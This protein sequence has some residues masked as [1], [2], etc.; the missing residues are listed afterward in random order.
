MSTDNQTLER[1][2]KKAN[3][4]ISRSKY[5]LNQQNK[6]D[7]QQQF[8]YQIN[9]RDKSPISPIT[10]Q[11]MAQIS[12]EQYKEMQI[13]R[14]QQQ[15][16]E[17][18]QN[19]KN[20]NQIKNF[21]YLNSSDE[22]D[23]FYYLQK[24]KRDTLNNSSEKSNKTAQ[25]QFQSGNTNKIQQNSNQN[26]KNYINNS[27]N[28]Q[29]NNN[30]NNLKFE[31]ILNSNASQQNFFLN[32]KIKNQQVPV[33]LY[34][35][36]F[37]IFQD[38]KSLNQKKNI[39]NQKDILQEQTQQNSKENQIQQEKKRQLS[40]FRDSFFSNADLNKENFDPN[41][42]LFNHDQ[43]I[44]LN[45]NQKSK[46]TSNQNIEKIIINNLDKQK[47]IPQNDKNAFNFPVKKD[48]QLKINDQKQIYQQ[49]L[50]EL[51]QNKKNQLKGL[52]KNLA[53]SDEEQESDDAKNDEIYEEDQN[54]L[55]NKTNLIVK[56][57]EQSNKNQFDN[58]KNQSPKNQ[59]TV[60]Y[61]NSL[62]PSQKIDL[63]I[64]KKLFAENLQE[65][66]D[67]Q[68]EKNLNN[69]EQEQIIEKSFQIK[70]T[71]FEEDLSANQKTYQKS[72]QPD[73]NQL[74]QQQI[75][76]SEK[77][78]L[79]TSSIKKNNEDSGFFEN[80]DKNFKVLIAKTNQKDPKKY[81]SNNTYHKQ[82]Q[83]IRKSLYG[84]F[85]KAWLQND[86]SAKKINVSNNQ[87]KYNDKYSNLTLSFLQQ[88]KEPKSNQNQNN[89]KNYNTQFSPLNFHVNKYNYTEKNA[90]QSHNQIN[91]NIPVSPLSN[92]QINNKNNR[93]KENK[94]ISD[95]ILNKKIG[96]TEKD[97]EKS[98]KLKFNRNQS[99]SL[100]NEKQN[101]KIINNPVKN[102][103]NQDLLINN[104]IQ[105]HENRFNS[106]N[107]NRNI[108]INFKNNNS[109]SFLTN[110]YN[111]N[112]QRTNRCN[113]NSSNTPTYYHNNQIK[114]YV[115]HN[116]DFNTLYKNTVQNNENKQKNIIFYQKRE[117]SQNSNYRS[118]SP[119]NTSNGIIHIQ[120]Q[121]NGHSNNKSSSN[122]VS[123]QPSFN[124]RYSTNLNN[125]CEKNNF[126]N[127]KQNLNQNLSQNQT[128]NYK[129][130][131]NFD[132]H[133][134]NNI[135]KFATT[136]T[137]FLNNNNSLNN[138]N[139]KISSHSYQTQNVLQLNNLNNNYNY[140]NNNYNNNNFNHYSNNNINSLPQSTAAYRDFRNLN[141]RGTLNSQGRTLS[142]Q[143][144]TTPNSYIQVN[145]LF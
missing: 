14:K 49:Q 134:N 50:K 36:H 123:S 40:Q 65:K 112:L 119:M 114:N 70:A 48:L 23:S 124:L 68:I 29:S 35:N 82:K 61:T 53:L 95:L 56:I 107:N 9:R 26:L 11:K 97:S 63:K 59:N 140:N 89:T 30:S 80:F 143:R 44:T 52:Q 136:K 22:E 81:L 130:Q 87:Q 137:T 122:L 47:Q 58:K 88:Q 66:S 13:Q 78:Q 104:N 33:N 43:N 142:I 132:K 12:F 19:N 99:S 117:T 31:Q 101:N 5:H 106:N 55:I 21:D 67:N 73:E 94:E 144:S 41:T 42:P 4:I 85:Q 109:Q 69:K 16:S 3:D 38:Q 86:N 72:K 27:N 111:N 145:K 126:E 139:K 2:L 39:N 15:K 24:T 129:I 6:F 20:I 90:N 84:E 46:A 115:I 133:Y 77:S 60:V 121:Q 76:N 91:Y 118:L 128:I 98:L 120:Q 7:E 116:N 57:Q 131:N 62:K 45:Q 51:K 141:I 10:H 17:I 92:F 71:D 1:I 108:N 127:F 54:I 8:E 34:E 96:E 135:N 103:Q 110:F 113:S 83:N 18:F 74:Q 100:L 25:F 138:L 37:E 102:N 75:Q 64:Q 93:A 79:T 125:N 105:S 28:N 32:Q